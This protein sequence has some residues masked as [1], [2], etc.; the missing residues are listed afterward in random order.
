M[1]E[2]ISSVKSPYIIGCIGEKRG[3]IKKNDEVY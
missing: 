2:I 1:F 3:E